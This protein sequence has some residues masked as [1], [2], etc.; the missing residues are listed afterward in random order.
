MTFDGRLLG[1]VMRRFDQKRLRYETEAAARQEEIYDKLPRVAEI[2]SELRL[3][4]LDIIKSTFSSGNSAAPMISAVKDHNLALQRERNELLLSHGY[5]YDY[6]QPHYDCKLCNDTGYVGANPCDCLLAAYYAEQNSALQEMFAGGL[7]TFDDFN[8]EYYSK[9]P[10]PGVGV[11][12]YE[13]ME[14]VYNFCVEYAKHFGAASENLF[15]SGASGLG[16]TMLASCIAGEVIKTGA[17]VVY[18]TA[19][20][21]FSR[22]EDEK[23]GRDIEGCTKR[24]HSAD[25]LIIDDLGME[26][27]TSFTTSVLYNLINARLLSGKKTI[28]CSNLSSAEVSKR[29]GTSLYSRISGD[30]LTLIFYGED[31]RIAKRRGI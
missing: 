5:S 9:T 27:S 3:T 4:I 1:A 24:Y 22:Y 18:D 7:S 2:D 8:I 6:T 13:Q 21:I 17:S 12:P 25:L 15:M 29:Y 11:S 19:F 31:V 16:K 30:Y 26:M 28:I 20:T 10:L 14:E 23:F